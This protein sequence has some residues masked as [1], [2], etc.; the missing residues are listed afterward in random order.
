M[1]PELSGNSSGWVH[2]AGRGGHRKPCLR[3]VHHQ[4]GH[5]MKLS[6]CS[7]GH[8]GTERGPVSHPGSPSSSVR[9]CPLKAF[10]GHLLSSPEPSGPLSACQSEPPAPGPRGLP[11]VT[12]YFKEGSPQEVKCMVPERGKWRA[13]GRRGPHPWLCFS[14]S[15]EKLTGVKRWL[16]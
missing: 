3:G 9:L 2:G 7:P 11:T 10:H 12:Y 16:K 14:K 13:G 5:S 1:A 6:V 4:G 8:H 15:G